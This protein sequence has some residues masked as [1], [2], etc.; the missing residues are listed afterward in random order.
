M[1]R[2]INVGVSVLLPRTDVPAA[3]LR[4]L[5]FISRVAGAMGIQALSQ[6]LSTEVSFQVGVYP[7]FRA[8]EV[9]QTLEGVGFRVVLVEQ[10]VG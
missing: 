10:N 3:A 1:P 2:S 7:E 5:R 6:R 4:E 9:A 8:K